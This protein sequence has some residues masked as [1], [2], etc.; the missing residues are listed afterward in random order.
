[1]DLLRARI[2]AEQEL[3]KHL[4][5]TQGWRFEFDTAEKRFGACHYG[6]KLITVSSILTEINSE[7][8]FLE[9]VRHEIAH[10][11][12]GFKAGHGR[13][14]KLI[15]NVTKCK[16]VACYSSQFVNNS[17]KDIALAKYARLDAV[18]KFKL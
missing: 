1:M 15:C 7:E 6:K 13:D 17:A 12:A 14:W 16:P 8:E 11:I 2:L 9:T 10:V 4:P 5:R 3:V 18:L